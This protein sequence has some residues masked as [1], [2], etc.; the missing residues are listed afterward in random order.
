MTNCGMLN[1]KQPED[2]A[3]AF[4][5]PQSRMFRLSERSLICP[6]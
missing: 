3:S 6:T 1:D 5:N 2:S 4:R